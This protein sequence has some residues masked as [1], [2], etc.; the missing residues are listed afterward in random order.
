[1]RNIG[2]IVLILAASC[3]L[4]AQVSG[5]RLGLLGG[6]AI[7]EFSAN[8]DY[9]TGDHHEVFPGYQAGMYVQYDSKIKLSYRAGLLWS[10]TGDYEDR[11]LQFGGPFYDEYHEIKYVH[12]DILLPMELMF[13]FSKKPNRF[14]LIGGLAPSVRVSRKVTDTQWWEGGEVTV[15]DITPQQH[16]RDMDLF[17]TLG[18]GYAFRPGGKLGMYVQPAISSNLPGNALDMREND[19]GWLEFQEPTVFTF[20]LLV[21][22]DLG[23]K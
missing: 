21:G 8:S 11:H 7:S 16:Y 14:Y 6:P 10:R 9:V 17:M 15:Y 22:V 13:N 4:G 1:M 2:I 3:T 19:L 5:W 12:E 23:V 20:S 18:M